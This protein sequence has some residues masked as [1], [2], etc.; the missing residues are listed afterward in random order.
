MAGVRRA[1]TTTMQHRFVVCPE[2]A[3]L[4]KIEY[5]DSPLGMLTFSCSRYASQCELGC[6]RACARHFDLRAR[7]WG[8]AAATAART[9]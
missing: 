9:D 8:L 4:E 1:L 2:T 5:L 7:L 3:H 6:S